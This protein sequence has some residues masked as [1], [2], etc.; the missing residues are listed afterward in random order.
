ML[1]RRYIIGAAAAVVFLA[2]AIFSF[3]KTSLEY[4]D[5][6]TA[7]ARNKKVQVR[8]SWL[9]DNPT[10]YDSDNNRFTFYAKDDKGKTARVIYSGPKPENFEIA[11]AFVLTGKYEGE[12]F[13]ASDIL[14]KC[15]SKYEGRTD[16]VEKHYE[17][18][19]PEKK[20]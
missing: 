9:K 7:A 5:F 6:T 12:D 2:L 10:S 13:V 8:C 17:A 14:M 18:H 4:T 20:L 16:E 3:D 15:P 1:K 19:K 11:L